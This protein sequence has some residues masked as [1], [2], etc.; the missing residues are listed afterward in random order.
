MNDQWPRWEA[1]VQARPG[2]PHE[3]AGSVHAPDA[4]IALQNA[5]DV[6]ARRPAVH[7]LWVVPATAITAVADHEFAHVV[8]LGGKRDGEAPVASERTSGAPYLIFIKKGHRASMTFVEH[9]ATVEAADARE[10]LRRAWDQV[11][12]PSAVRVW[13]AVPKAAVVRSDPADVASLFDPAKDK[14]YRQ[15][16][17]Y[18]TVVA[19]KRLKERKVDE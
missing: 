7:S 9:A 1:F 15:P 11:E 13:W 8:P 18:R 17:Q 19:M 4:E 3:N 10:A 6:F 14:L 5:R 16:N 2:R 12:E